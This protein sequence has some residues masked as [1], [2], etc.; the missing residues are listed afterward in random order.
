MFSVASRLPALLCILFAGSTSAR[1]DT[2]EAENM[3][4]AEATARWAYQNCPGIQI[5]PMVLMLAG[6]VGK[7][8]SKE[9]LDAAHSRLDTLMK[10]RFKT[11]EEG[12]KSVA[13]LLLGPK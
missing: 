4:L 13:P 2:A 6:L 9:Q 1:S 5:N 7:N 11:V 10:A 3:L 8:A 12:C